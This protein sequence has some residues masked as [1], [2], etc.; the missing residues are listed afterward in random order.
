MLDTHII[1]AKDTLN[2]CSSALLSLRTFRERG[3]YA[4]HVY[5]HAGGTEAILLWTCWFPR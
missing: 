3:H 5:Q 2:V 1:L 4:D